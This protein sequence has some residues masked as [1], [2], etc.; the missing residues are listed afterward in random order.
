MD[1][2]ERRQIQ[3]ANIQVV[4]VTTPANYFHVLRRQVHRDFRKPLIVMSPKRLL[5]H[6]R[7]ISGLEEFSDKGSQPRFRRVINDTTESLVSNDRIRKVLFC[8]GNVYYDLVEHREKAGVNDVAI[9]RVEQLAPFPFDRV[10]EQAQRYSNASVAWV[11]EE[12]M[13]QGAWNFVSPHMRTAFRKA[14]HAH[15]E[16]A[17]VGRA[18]SASTATGSAKAHKRQLQHLLD[19]ALA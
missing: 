5:R 19:A 10:A 13:N 11:Q 9:V 18:V 4:N 15:P 14:G 1:P 17:Y 16:P 2:T 12:P 7:C 8:S 6:P 3:Q